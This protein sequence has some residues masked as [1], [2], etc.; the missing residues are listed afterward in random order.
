[1]TAAQRIARA[2]LALCV[3]GGAACSFDPSADAVPGDMD[4]AQADA[5]GNVPDAAP[6]DAAPPPLPTHVVISEVKA[7]PLGS[8]FIEIFNAGCDA[9]DLSVYYVT[10]EPTYGLLPA[11]GSEP[12]ELEHQDIVMRFPAGSVL[13]AGEVAI[14]ARTEPGFTTA[15]GFTPDYTVRTPALAPQMETIA[16]G[17]T[18]DFEILNAGEPIILFRWDGENDLV[19]DVDIVV[20]GEAPPTGSQLLAKQDVAPSGVDG[21]DRDVIATL[22][23]DDALSLLPME[24]GDPGNAPGIG[25]YQR[26]TLEGAAEIDTAGNGIDE[27]DETS[28]DTR[29][30]WEQTVGTVPTPGAVPNG[31]R[32]PCTGPP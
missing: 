10:D 24:V 31:L 25:A 5:S 26:V 3:A 8:E 15:F 30:T 4:A 27:H 9:V 18:T 2:L 16:R 11:W 6:A 21:P 19:T 20:A 28:E 32:A 17:D 14:V 12:P 29:M 22:Y 23:R 13:E 1:M 7:H